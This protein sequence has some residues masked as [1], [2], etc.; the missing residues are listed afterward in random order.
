VIAKCFD[1]FLAKFLVP[2]RHGQSRSVNRRNDKA[3]DH[4]HHRPCGL[5][6]G[7]RGWS[8]GSAAWGFGAVWQRGTVAWRVQLLA[9]RMD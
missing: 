3:A 6:S 7:Q 1:V 4:G 8:E 2:A 9:L 5:G